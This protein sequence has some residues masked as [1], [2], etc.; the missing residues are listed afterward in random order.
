MTLAKSLLI[1]I[2]VAA[3]S[4]SWSQQDPIEKLAG[5]WK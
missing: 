5:S 3:P 4:I 1:M 2:L